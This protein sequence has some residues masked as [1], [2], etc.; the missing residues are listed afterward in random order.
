MIFFITMR[1][2]CSRHLANE[3]YETKEIFRQSTIKY[4][5]SWSR[6]IRITTH[7]IQIYLSRLCLYLSVCWAAQLRSEVRFLCNTSL[8]RIHSPWTPRSSSNR[9]N[10]KFRNNGTESILHLSCCYS[11]LSELQQKSYCFCHT[12]TLT[13]EPH[14]AWRKEGWNIK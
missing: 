1:T 8:A 9:N 7:S 2:P 12:R 6:H 10:L 11:A 3:Q 4:Y 14:T 5:Y 13:L